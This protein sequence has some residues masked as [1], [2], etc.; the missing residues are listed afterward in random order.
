MDKNKDKYR[1][2]IFG[3][4]I[5]MT[6]IYLCSHINPVIILL[7]SVLKQWF[8]HKLKALLR[9]ITQ[10]VAIFSGKYFS[11]AIFISGLIFSAP[12]LLLCFN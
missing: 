6:V 10:F 11:L 3:Q 9:S 8:C 2:L 7:D 12:N 4:T 5:I 1:M